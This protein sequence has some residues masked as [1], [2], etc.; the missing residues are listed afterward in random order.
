MQLIRAREDFSFD[1]DEQL[2][3]LK[4]FGIALGEQLRG[5]GGK[6]G[7]PLGEVART[8]KMC[9]SFV[10]FAEDLFTAWYWKGDGGA[11]L[12]VCSQGLQERCVFLD[13][14]EARAVRVRALGE[15]NEQK[16]ERQK[17]ILRQKEMADAS[18]DEDAGSE[19]VV[20][21]TT[22]LISR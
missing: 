10:D 11:E 21:Q 9:E 19:L 8:Q 18:D 16:A 15:L 22:L 5:M 12:N 3:G 14:A 13:R 6:M 4:A 7:D 17:E 20:Q 1:L 2:D